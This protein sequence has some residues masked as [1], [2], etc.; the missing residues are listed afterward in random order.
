MKTADRSHHAL[1]L[2][3]DGETESQQGHSEHHG[4]ML[5]TLDLNRTVWYFPMTATLQLRFTQ[6]QPPKPDFCGMVQLWLLLPCL[7]VYFKPLQKKK[8]LD[9]VLILATSVDK[10]G[11]VAQRSDCVSQ[12]LQHPSPL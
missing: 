5:A 6:Q 2:C 3:F 9:F 12:E 11:S 1:R 10:S 4:D 7:M 8:T